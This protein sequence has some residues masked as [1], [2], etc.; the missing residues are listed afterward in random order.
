MKL[1]SQIFFVSLFLISSV[2]AASDIKIEKAWSP[3]AP[4]VVKVMAGYMKIYNSSNKDIKII[5][6]KSDS[7]KRVEIH[8]SK[9]KNGMMSMIKQ[10]N[11]NIKAKGHIE[12]KSGGLHMMLM[13]KLN[14]IKKGS[15]IPVT[16]TFDNG[17]T[18]D[19]KLKVKT[20]N[21]PQMKCG[22][23]KCGSM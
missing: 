14:P 11:L 17:E 5:S 20:D 16:L 3:E 23:G 13:G 12:L 10:E 7:F 18:I 4:P 15:V 22:S 1:V 21:K 6:A 19:I 9:M 8:L 2:H